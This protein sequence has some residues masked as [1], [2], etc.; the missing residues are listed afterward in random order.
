[1]T[2]RTSTVGGGEQIYL[3]R[4]SIDSGFVE[5]GIVKRG[6]SIELTTET[7]SGSNVWRNGES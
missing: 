3:K 4:L 2:V 7:I 6:R 1:V 5:A